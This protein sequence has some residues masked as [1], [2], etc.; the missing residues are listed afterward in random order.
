MPISVACGACGKSFSVADTFAGKTGKCACGAAV[1]VPAAAAPAAVAAAPAATPPSGH[2]PSQAA[3]GMALG[4]YKLSRKL[5]DPK[6]SVFLATSAEGKQVALKVLPDKV[7]AQFPAAAKRFLREARS[8]FGLEHPNVV[9]CLDAGEELGCLYLSMEYFDGKTVREIL[10]ERGG[11]LPEAEA[12]AIAT[13]IAQAIGHFDSHKLVHRNVK[14]EHILVAPRGA[15]K[16][17]GLG[18]V[19]GGDDDAALTQKGHLVGTPQ[20]MSP[21]Q[22]RGQREIDARSDLFSLGT[23]LYEMLAGEVPWNDKSPFK[24]LYA[25]ENAPPPPIREKNPA[26][27]EKT[28]RVLEKLLAKDPAA[29]YQTPA[30]VIA[31]LGSSG[32]AAP[33]AAAPAAAAPGAT[34]NEA[35]VKK[36]V[37][38]VIVLVVVVLALV[39]TLVVA[40]VLK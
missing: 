23:T 25:I 10:A 18:L 22:A 5:G 13:Q 2:L 15:A 9:S 31:A 21:E 7:T 8:L 37:I 4:G 19:K 30:E 24:V 35:M 36:L 39:A 14:P 27:S 16:L 1:Q 17:A 32:S 11:R 29:R 34:G 20:Y 28:A 26:V 38:L 33:A 40:L 3:V 6:S 12:V